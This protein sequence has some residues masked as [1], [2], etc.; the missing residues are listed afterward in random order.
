MGRSREYRITVRQNKIQKRKKAICNYGYSYRK[1]INIALS[2]EKEGLFHKNHY[3]AL[4][5]GIKTKTKNA[6]ASYRH[7]GGYGKAC[8]YSR[9][10]KLQIICMNEKIREYNNKSI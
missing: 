3:G 8:V 7:K 9:H 1:K 5:N 10:D 2:G 6:Y 4:G